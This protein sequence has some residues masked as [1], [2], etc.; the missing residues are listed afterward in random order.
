MVEN[1]IKAG[2][3]EAIKLNEFIVH[4][5]LQEMHNI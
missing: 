5:D 4:F 3:V 1:N 2:R